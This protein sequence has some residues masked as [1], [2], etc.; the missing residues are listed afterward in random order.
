MPH[1]DGENP[2]AVATIED[3]IGSDNDLSETDIASLRQSPSRFG[4]PGS[5]LQ[6]V[7]DA[8]M[9]SPRGA[10]IVL[11]DVSKDR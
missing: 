6:R 2:A 10:G 7:E 8:S 3:P 1:A 9:E 4:K 5:D 11:G